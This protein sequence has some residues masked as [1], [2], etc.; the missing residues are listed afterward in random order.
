[1]GKKYFAS[2]RIISQN[3]AS[4]LGLACLILIIN[5]PEDFSLAKMG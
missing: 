4:N 1:M 2:T 5:I 3:G